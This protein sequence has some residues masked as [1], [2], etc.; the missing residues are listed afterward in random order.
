MRYTK[1]NESG[2]Q[3]ENVLKGGKFSVS[4]FFCGCGGLDLGFRGD[5]EYHGERYEEQPFCIQEAYDFNEPC[6][7]TYNRYF[8][9]HNG[10]RAEV[11]DLSQADVREFKA[12]DVLI[13]GFPCQ[14]F[15]SCGPLGGLDSERGQLYKVL[16]RYMEEYRP[17][18]VVGENVINL[19]RMNDGA[20][21][22]T[23]IKDLEAVGYNVEVWNLFAPDYGIP[24]RRN[25][26]FF[27]CI[28][29]D[30]QGF[31]IKPEPKFASNHRT[32]KWAIGDLVDIKD[33]SIPNQSQ[34]F[35]ASKAKKGNGQGDEV[36]DGNKPAYTIRANP[37]SRVQFHYSL[38][39]RLSVRECARIQTFPDDFVF[40]HSKTTSMSQIGN[41]VPPVLAYLVATSIA[42]FMRKIT[43][44]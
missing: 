1:Q 6:V 23:I 4:S 17:S 27:I 34:F 37:K 31:P 10:H 35:A 2:T 33:E 43:N 25:R 16:I 26:L 9:R 28:R 22:R 42:D 38:P 15:S 18:V 8:V 36:N 12:S 40:K 30:L 39:R 14:E 20:V 13:G 41:A 21:I 24:Q 7:E 3:S 32:I 44:K 11:K 29:K 19:L 5:F